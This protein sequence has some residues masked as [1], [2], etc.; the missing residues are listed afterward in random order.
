MAEN[1]KEDLEQL[2]VKKEIISI[3]ED[4]LPSSTVE[5]TYTVYKQED[6]F[7][8]STVEDTCTVYKQE[9]TFPYSTVEDTCTVYKQE[10]DAQMEF[11]EIKGK[12]LFQIL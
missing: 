3:Q 7:P 1:M 4:I 6:T 2:E 11:T 8:Y 12:H 9:D 5:D 10:E